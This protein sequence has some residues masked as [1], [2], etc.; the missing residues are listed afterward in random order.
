M[1]G[2]YAIN[3]QNRQS[4]G[5]S[6]MFAVAADFSSDGSGNGTISISPAIVISGPLQNVSNAPAANSAIVVQG[7]ANVSSARG[8]AFHPDFATFACAD[9]PLYLGLDKADRQADD[10]IG[11]SIRVIRD[12]DI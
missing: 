7:A 9:L 4:T 11:M 2:V 8:L 1:A 5:S 6:A 3:P 10:Q 12:Y